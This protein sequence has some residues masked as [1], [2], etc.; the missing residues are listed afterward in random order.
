MWEAKVLEGIGEAGVERLIR[1]FYQQIPDDPRLG[2]M[3]PADELEAAEGR[4]RDFVIFRLGGSQRY[5]EQ[6]GHPRLRQRHMPFPVDQDARDRWVQLMDNA[7]ERSE[8]ADE[9]AQPLRDFFAE[10]ATFLI[11]RS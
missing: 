6:R 11:Q 5:V 9:Y 2:P 8:I 10:V 4:L 1:E 3:Y 7:F